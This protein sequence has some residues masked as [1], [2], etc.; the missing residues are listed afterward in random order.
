[1]TYILGKLYSNGCDYCIELKPEWE[2]MKNALKPHTNIHIIEIEDTIMTEKLDEL[3]KTHSTNVQ[4]QIGFP[5]IFW[6]NIENKKVE[7]Y[8]GTRDSSS[9]IAWALSHI[10]KQKRSRS[11]FRKISRRVKR[12]ISGG[13]RHRR[14]RRT[15]KK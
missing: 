4:L 7:Y 6:V 1:M 13:K 2:S 5:T 9:L 14:R 8:N 11:S 12:R 15:C 10:Q 3:N